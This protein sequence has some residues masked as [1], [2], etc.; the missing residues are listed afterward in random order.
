MMNSDSKCGSTFE[1]LKRR[2]EETYLLVLIIF[3]LILQILCS[4]IIFYLDLEERAQSDELCIKSSSRHD[5]L[6]Y[7]LSEQPEQ[8]ATETYK[9][10]NYNEYDMD[11]T[12]E[13]LDN[14][15][16][17]HLRIRSRK[18]SYECSEGIE[19]TCSSCHKKSRILSS[20]M[21]Q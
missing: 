18:R 14:I 6:I 7:I 3:V 9:S 8:Q 5:N 2:M 16:E 13:E 21:N 11:F 19:G 12:L 17:N 4:Q 10:S 1:E 15:E 20:Y